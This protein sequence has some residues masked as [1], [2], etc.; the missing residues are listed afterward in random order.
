MGGNIFGVDQAAFERGDG[1]GKYRC[2]RVDGFPLPQREAL[3]L[4]EMLLAGERNG[5]RLLRGA[6]SIERENAILF[7]NRVERIVAIE[8]NQQRGGII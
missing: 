7:K 1:A 5:E 8:A 4:G 6:Q 2:A 3:V